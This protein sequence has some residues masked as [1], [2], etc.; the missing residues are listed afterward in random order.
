MSEIFELGDQA[1]NELAALYPEWG[2]SVG[3]AGLDDKWSDYSPAGQAKVR[4]WYQ[5]LHDRAASAQTLTPD[6]AT[7]QRVILDEAQRAL[8]A[9][10]HDYHFDLNNIASPWQGVRETVH[11]QDQK[12]AENWQDIATRLETTADALDAYRLSLAEGLASGRVVARRQVEIAA[13]QGRDA[14]SDTSSYQQ[15]LELAE[16]SAA[17]NPALQSRLEAGARSA[18]AAYSDVT[19]WLEADYAPNTTHRD[20]VGRDYYEGRVLSHL[21]AQLDLQETY[22]W[23]WSE[24]H[25]LC[26][27]RDELC[28]QIDSDSSPAEVLHR[29]GTDPAHG[30]GSADEFLQVMLDRQLRALDLLDQEAF[31]VPAPVRSIEVHAAPPGGASAAHYLPPSEDFSRPGKVMYPLFGRSFFPLYEEITTA[32]HEGFPGHH[33]QVG[34]QM[35]M[36]ERLSRFHRVAVWSPGSGEGWAL[37]AERLMDELG[38]FERPEYRLGLTMSQLFRSSRVVIDI[39]SH[40]ELPIPHDARFHPGE[41]WSYDLAVEMLH[42]EAHYPEPM[43]HSEVLRYF[44][45]PAQAISYKVGE[46]AILDMREVRRARPDY[47]E[48]QFHADVLSA[49]SVGLDLLRDLVLAE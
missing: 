37:Y 28:A 1:V 18:Q 15:L 11:H 46:R 42:T 34:W 23:G 22:D 13:E 31:D 9:G 4:S 3:V 24:V 45:W 7:A 41:N 14:A 26:D 25:R 33:L 20:G 2:S 43:C 12:T 21:G 49:G 48:K 10:E 16:A 38:F 30:A 35:A 32:Y 40:L 6:E 5:S 44:G 8:G 36:G 29:L 17:V 39:G 27:E 19:D 47:N